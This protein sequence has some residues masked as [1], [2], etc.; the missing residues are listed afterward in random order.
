MFGAGQ[1]ANRDVVFSRMKESL[2]PRLECLGRGPPWQTSGPSLGRQV[3]FEMLQGFWMAPSN[4]LR[5][6]DREEKHA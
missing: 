5:I 4:E 1:A 6:Q 3:C 2:T